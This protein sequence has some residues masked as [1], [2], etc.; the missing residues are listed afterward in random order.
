MGTS[1][2]EATGVS[3]GAEALVVGAWVA[4]AAF[5]PARSSGS[6][7]GS[8]VPGASAA[9]AATSVMAEVS[10]AALYAV[11]GAEVT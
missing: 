9:A 11:V 8:E 3:V 4:G 6:G 1:G 2:T 10:G 5:V 7:P